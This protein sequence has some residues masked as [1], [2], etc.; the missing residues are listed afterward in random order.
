MAF[1]GKVDLEQARLRRVTPKQLGDFPVETL[2]D[3]QRRENLALHLTSL[4]KQLDIAKANGDKHTKLEIG[5]KML[6]VIKEIAA[7]KKIIK[8]R[9]SHQE[10]SLQ[11]YIFQVAKE[12]MTKEQW[13]DVIEEARR[14]V[15]QLGIRK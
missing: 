4:Q 7:L 8:K 2:T 5:Q 6:V 15:F 1:K 12:R 11:N 14:R 10:T 9:R 13:N 3:E